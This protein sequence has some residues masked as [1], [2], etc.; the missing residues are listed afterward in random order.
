MTI[1]NT[2]QWRRTSQTSQEAKI[3]SSE[4]AGHRPPQTRKTTWLRILS[5]RANPEYGFSTLIHYLLFCPICIWHWWRVTSVLCECDARNVSTWLVNIICA[6][7]SSKT[8]GCSFHSWTFYCVT[9]NL[10]YIN[11]PD[12]GPFIQSVLL[13][14]NVFYVGRCLT[15]TVLFF[16]HHTT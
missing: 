11:Q 4:P 1:Q 10:G 3:S 8:L 6:G 15:V 13:K 7:R 2:R 14:K 9:A 16:Q 5:N 12:Y